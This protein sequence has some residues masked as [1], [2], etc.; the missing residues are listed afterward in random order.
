MF[1]RSRSPTRVSMN[2]ARPCLRSGLC[3]KALGSGV[4]APR[5]LAR[6]KAGQA[7]GGVPR[8][9]TDRE[10][11]EPVIPP[12]GLESNTHRPTRRQGDLP[13]DGR[14]DPGP[15]SSST[16]AIV[17]GTSSPGLSTGARSTTR[18]DTSF[19]LSPR[20]LVRSKRLPFEYR[21]A[22]WW[23]SV[24]GRAGCVGVCGVRPQ[25]AI[26]Q[27]VNEFER[28]LGGDEVLEHGLGQSADRHGDEFGVAFGGVRA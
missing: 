14:V 26:E 21:T 7:M 25:H 6:G 13:F 9:G 28:G 22:L 1:H 24:R 11:G 19:G 18:H 17:S 5:S 15:S 10:N 16:M 8:F 2:A 12:V 4:G 23:R 20:A 27:M 3:C